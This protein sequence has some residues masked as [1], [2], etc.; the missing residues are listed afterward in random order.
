MHDALVRQRGNKLRPHADRARD[1]ENGEHH[2]PHAQRGAQLVSG[3][4]AHPVPTGEHEHDV[5]ARDRN[6]E[7]PVGAKP[8]FQPLDAHCHRRRSNLIK[9][10]VERSR[11]FRFRSR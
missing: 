1:A 2:V 10:R 4:R 3:P 6:A 7:R 9:A 8:L 11:S 5:D